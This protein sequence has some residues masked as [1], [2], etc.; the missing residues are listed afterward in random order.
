MALE[1][2]FFN[3]PITNKNRLWQ[4]AILVVWSARYMEILYS[5]FQ[6]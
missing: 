2:I 6:T 4:L 3:C 5:I 1:K